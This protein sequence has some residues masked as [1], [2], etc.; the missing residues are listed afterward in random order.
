MNTVDEALESVSAR[1][2][3]RMKEMLDRL[4]YDLERKVRKPSPRGQRDLF[5][6]DE[7]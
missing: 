6:F 7:K 5:D 1:K 4:N 3:E 2:E